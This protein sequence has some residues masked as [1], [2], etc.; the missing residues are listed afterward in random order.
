MH[1]PADIELRHKG[2]VAALLTSP[3]APTVA[4][5]YPHTSLP[6]ALLLYKHTGKHLTELMVVDTPVKPGVQRAIVRP[7]L[8]AGL[9][10]A[11]YPG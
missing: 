2:L 4:A 9:L 6:I 1:W 3:I 5:A 11:P 7:S 8:I 10:G